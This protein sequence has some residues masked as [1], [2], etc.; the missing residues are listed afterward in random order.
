LR[1][2]NSDAWRTMSYLLPKGKVLHDIFEGRLQEASA[3]AGDPARVDD[4]CAAVMALPRPI[5]IRY[6]AAVTYTTAQQIGDFCVDLN[7]AIQV[8]DDHASL[9]DEDFETFLRTRVAPSLPEFQARVADVL[10]QRHRTDEYAAIHV[11]AALYD[12]RRG[13]DIIRLLEM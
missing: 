2:G 4:F 7:P 5:P 3:K 1:Y 13:K 8:A 12:A 9:A 11:A 10:F 6:L